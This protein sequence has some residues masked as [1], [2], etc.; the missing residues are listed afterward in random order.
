MDCIFGSGALLQFRWSRPRPQPIRASGGNPSL[1]RHP[2]TA[3]GHQRKG[4]ESLGVTTATVVTE[5]SRI[6]MAAAFWECAR[7]ATFV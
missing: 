5:E 6:T 1:P 4:H 7:T 2:V 3:P